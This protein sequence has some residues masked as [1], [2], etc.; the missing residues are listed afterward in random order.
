MVNGFSA[1]TTNEEWVLKPETKMSD[2]RFAAVMNEVRSSLSSKDGLFFPSVLSHSNDE[3]SLQLA[4]DIQPDLHWFRGHFPG[5]PV[6]PGVVQLH[7][8]VTIAIAY[9]GIRDV[10]C[11]VLR[12]KFKSIVVPPSTVDFTLV[13]AMPEDVR[14]AY[15]GDGRQYSEGQLRFNG[16]TR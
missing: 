1:D 8:A 9:F 15:T 2:R 5:H 13:R 14:F 7:W 4:L 10:P 11:Q 3:E 6:L 12:L 16:P